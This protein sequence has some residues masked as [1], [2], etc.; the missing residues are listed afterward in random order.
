MYWILFGSVELTK[1]TLLSRLGIGATAVGGLPMVVR[2]NNLSKD[3][4]EFTTIDVQA[5]E[6]HNSLLFTGLS[7]TDTILYYARGASGVEDEA[8][9]IVQVTDPSQ[10]SVWNLTEISN[11][12]YRYW[13]DGQVHEVT[14]NSDGSISTAKPVSNEQTPQDMAVVNRRT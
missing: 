7:G 1:R 9:D 6:R 14:V 4:S 3:L 11:T 2:A 12:T 5:V 13:Q 10:G 8:K